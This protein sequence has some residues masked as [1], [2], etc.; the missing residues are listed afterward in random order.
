MVLISQS[1]E[2]VNFDNLVSIRPQGPYIHA[3]TAYGGDIILGTYQSPAR[4]AEVMEAFI[5]DMYETPF[6][7]ATRYAFPTE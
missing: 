6:T 3:K 2:V 5:S 1:N 4:A 7:M